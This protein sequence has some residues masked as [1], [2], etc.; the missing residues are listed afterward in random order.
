[1]R[2]DPRI[3]VLVA[4]SL[5]VAV[6]LFLAGAGAAQDKAKPLAEF[7]ELTFDFGEVFEQAQ[8]AHTFTVRNRGKADLIIEDVK[9]G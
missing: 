9:P 2:R 5:L 7:S 6:V 1:V 4:A 3:R 8:Y